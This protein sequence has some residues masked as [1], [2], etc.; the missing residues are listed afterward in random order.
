MGSHCYAT[1]NSRAGFRIGASRCL[2]KHRRRT[3]TCPGPWLRRHG[4]ESLPG[5]DGGKQAAVHP[6]AG[7]IRHVHLAGYQQPAAKPCRLVECH[8]WRRR[9]GPS[10][11]RFHSSR[12]EPGRSFLAA[13][14][15]SIDLRDCATR[16]NARHRYRRVEHST[17]PRQAG[18]TAS[19]QCVLGSPGDQRCR[20]G[21]LPDAGQ[22]PASRGHRVRPFQLSLRHGYAGPVGDLR[23][24]HPVH[25]GCPISP[26]HRTGRQIRQLVHDRT[27]RY[28]ATDRPGEFFES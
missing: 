24:V 12:P 26:T 8:Q 20:Y 3:A 17:D 16:K 10:D 15:L 27:S 9:R 6:A 14:P 21:H 2:G 25:A 11:F 18:I 22:L 19:R 1:P 13:A 23:R 7:E 28:G 5:T 4:P